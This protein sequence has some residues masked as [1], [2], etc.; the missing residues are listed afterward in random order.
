MAANTAHPCRGD[1]VIRPNVTV[2]PAG[3]AKMETVI[4]EESARLNRLISQAFEMAQL[5]AQHVKLQ[6]EFR[7][8]KDAVGQAVSECGGLLQAHR[9]EVNLPPGLPPV[10]MDIVWIRKVLHHLLENAAKYSQPGT[11]VFI[12]A[13]MRDSFVITSVADRGVGIDDLDKALIFDKF[14]RG[15]GQRFRV[16]GTGMGLAL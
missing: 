8:L 4:E 15:Q 6:L 13:E 9:I 12:S 11:P 10:R 5:D 3:M 1:L 7:Q 16:Q 14:Y 2:S